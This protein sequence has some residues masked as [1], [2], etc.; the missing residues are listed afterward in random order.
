MSHVNSPTPSK[1][2]ATSGAKEQ[3]DNS[4]TIGIA[5]GVSGAIALL[6]VLCAFGFWWYRRRQNGYLGRPAHSQRIH[7]QIHSNSDLVSF[8]GVA[9][10]ERAR[11]TISPWQQPSSS[12]G[13][14]AESTDHSFDLSRGHSASNS[15]GVVLP[16]HHR[17]TS[18]TTE[19][20]APQPY[21]S[22]TQSSRLHQS[23]YAYDADHEPAPVPVAQ[24]LALD[25]L[26][27][28]SVSTRQ[29]RLG[30]SARRRDAS[31]TDTTNSYES[32]TSS[33]FG[34]VPEPFVANR[35]P[36]PAVPAHLRGQIGRHGPS[37]LASDEKRKPPPG[38]FNGNTTANRPAPASTSRQSTL[39]PRYSA[40][41]D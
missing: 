10:D 23:H 40:I 37:P 22:D 5:A 4:D 6:L 7:S 28:P 20:L 16:G 27:V 12:S 32:W 19:L 24:G 31:P 25:I 21:G 13:H 15:L 1:E 39:P 38:A 9:M 35:P 29:N 33:D 41:L 14:S 11:R 18:S 3:E 8:Q 2:N 36:V 34:P 17:R 26:P 30:G